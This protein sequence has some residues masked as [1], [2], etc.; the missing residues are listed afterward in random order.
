MGLK[1][2]QCNLDAQGTRDEST[3]VPFMGFPAPRTSLLRYTDDPEGRLAS[4]SSPWHG[5]LCLV[6]KTLGYT[7]RDRSYL[8]QACTHASYYQ[9]R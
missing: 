9:N 5:R 6:E 3:A 1:L 8:L 7:F 2:Q 4:Q